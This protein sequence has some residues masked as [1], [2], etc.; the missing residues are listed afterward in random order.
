[1][2]L[3]IYGGSFNPPHKG[4]VAAA[5]AAADAI[6]PDKFFIIPDY[7]PPHKTLDAASPSPAQRL[8]MTRLAFADVPGAEVTELEISRAGKS[9]TA[10]TVEYFS[11]KYPGSE[12]LLVIGSDML[13]TFTEW[14]R[15]EYLL[16]RCT[17]IVLSRFGSDMAQLDAYAEHL[18]KGFGAKVRIVE[19]DPVLT[20][21]SILRSVIAA[22]GHDAAIPEKV[23][24]YIK[25]N[26]LYKNDF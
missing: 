12:I 6:R 14:Y 7:I 18:K 11:E 19:H 16:G 2:R 13:L 3:L 9:Y 26:G 20:S 21:S 22:G 1:M 17:L 5:M 24:E 10:D 15:F 25:I 23:Y 8:E 4:H